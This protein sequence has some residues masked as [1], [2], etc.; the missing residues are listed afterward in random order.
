MKH[1]RIVC[2]IGL[3]SASIIAAKLAIRENSHESNPLPVVVVA[4]RYIG[5]AAL[6]E[7]M[8]YL[9]IP[10]TVLSPSQFLSFD[11]PG[12]VHVWGV[13]ADEQDAHDNLQTL[14]PSR[15]IASVLADRALRRGDCIELARRAGLSWFM[16]VARCGAEQVAA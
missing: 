4:H 13:P 12:D 15:A 16:P 14:F 5:N 3:D 1:E 6:E 7:A 11:K 10:V 8:N 2:W 9:G